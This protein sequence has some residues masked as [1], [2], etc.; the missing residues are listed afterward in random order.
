MKLIRFFLF[1]FAAKLQ[2]FS[3]Y[4]SKNIHQ[5]PIE[6]TKKRIELSR[7]YQS[8]HYGIDSSSIEIEPKMIILHWTCLPTLELALRVFNPEMLPANSPRRQE[9]P[10]DLNVSSHYLVDRD[11]SIYQLM[12]ENW[13]ARHVIGLNH[14]AIGIENV[15][16]IDGKDDLTEKQVE[17]NAFLVCYLKNKY[18][19]I[20]DVI[21]HHEY[22]RYKNT[23]LWLEKDPDYERLKTD[24][25]SNFVNR[26]NALVAQGSKS[27]K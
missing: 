26:V 16:G 3:C 15:G 6:F 4:D 5:K 7:L 22:L 11:G 21:G 12:P 27:Q 25:G 2:A 20:K 23:P 24:P 17:A 1:L 8:T 18:P 10:D 9:I 14:Y 19:G 13:M